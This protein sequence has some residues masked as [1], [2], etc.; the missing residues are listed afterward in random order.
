[1]LQVCRTMAKKFDAKLADETFEKLCKNESLRQAIH[2]EMI[3]FG[4]A[5]KLNSI[6]CV[7]I[8]NNTYHYTHLC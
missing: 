3:K 2:E 5:N 7:S 4:K 1:M 6:E 8:K